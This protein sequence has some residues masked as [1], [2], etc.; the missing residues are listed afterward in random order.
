MIRRF[1]QLPRQRYSDADDAVRQ[2][3]CTGRTIV[4]ESPARPVDIVVDDETCGRLVWHRAAAKVLNAS[5]AEPASATCGAC[6]TSRRR[7]TGG[8]ITPI[9]SSP[10]LG[11]LYSNYRQPRHPDL[12]PWLADRVRRRQDDQ[13]GSDV[14][15]STP[16]SWSKTLVHCDPTRARDE[17]N[18]WAPAEQL[19]VTPLGREHGRQLRRSHPGHRQC[20]SG[21]TG[22]RHRLIRLTGFTASL[23]LCRPAPNVGFPRLPPDLPRSY[24]TPRSRQAPEGAEARAHGQRAAQPMD[25]V[26][27]VGSETRLGFGTTTP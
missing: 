24:F 6:T 13:E 15:C 16:C 25:L 7:A 9:R 19:D 27:A 8:C 10:A 12:R 26:C 22:A 2:S 18:G 14:G 17:S 4:L 11:F 5:T 21:S 1:H 20:V 3:G 23:L